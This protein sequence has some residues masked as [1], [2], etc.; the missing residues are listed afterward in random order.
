MA[1]QTRKTVRLSDELIQFIEEQPG[2]H[3]T[4]KLESLL[5]K[6]KLEKPIREREI[7]RLEDKISEANKRILE[8]KEIQ[9]EIDKLTEHMKEYAE[10]IL[11]S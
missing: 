3:F 1:K 8:F 9:S 5:W 4:E 6:Q 11:P 10:R 2:E 7:Q